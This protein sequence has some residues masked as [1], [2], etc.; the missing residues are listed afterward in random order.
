M[1]EKKIIIS[2][3]SFAYF[4]FLKFFQKCIYTICVSFKDR[5]VDD[6]DDVSSLSS[7]FSVSATVVLVVGAGA[8]VRLV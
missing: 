3:F 2:V 8:G 7:A 6:M 4:A 1:I 5:D